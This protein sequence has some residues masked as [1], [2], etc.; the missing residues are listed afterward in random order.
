MSLNDALSIALSTLWNAEKVGRDECLIN[1][2]SKIITSVL[3]ILK[4]EEYIKDFQVIKQ[5]KKTITKISLLGNIN[6][7]LAI[8][9]RY[10]LK[11]EDYKKFEKRYLPATNVGILIVSTNKGIMTHRESRQNNLGGKLIAFC[12]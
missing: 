11:I 10:P 6:K 7:C 5:G 8:K 12:Y 4:R 2:N 3:N 1:F 9:P